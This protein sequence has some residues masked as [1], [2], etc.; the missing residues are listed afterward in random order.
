MLKQSG[1]SQRLR[2][3]DIDFVLESI[4]EVNALPIF[5]SEPM[6]EL[7]ENNIK[8]LES[9]LEI[10]F[11]SFFGEEKYKTIEEKAAAL[12]YYVSKNHAFPNGNKRTAVILMLLFLDE[13]EKWV[14]FSAEEL[15]DYSIKITS[16]K[17]KDH[18]K[19][20]KEISKTLR[21]RIINVNTEIEP[22]KT[23]KK[24]QKEFVQG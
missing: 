18:E 16:D 21:E 19:R 23:L 20:I 10:P 11:V 7:N 14:D 9:A 1:N 17:N 2:K 13:N 8:K 12:L 6:Y 22:T 4:R 5:G 15:Y 3:P 24:A